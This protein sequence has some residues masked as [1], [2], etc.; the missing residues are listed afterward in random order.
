MVLIKTLATSSACAMALAWFTG[1]PDPQAPPRPDGPPRD[2]EPRRFEFGPGGPGG[3]GGFPGRGPGGFGG[4]GG[5]GGMFGGERKL[6]EKFDTDKNGWLDSGERKAARE[7][8]KSE[9]G[10]GRPGGP[11]GF[12]PPGGGPPGGFGGREEVSPKPGPRV[13]VADVKPVDE[14]T[15][16][17]DPETIRTIF[18]EFEN[19]DWDAEMAEFYKSDVEVPAKMIVDGKEYPNVGVGYRGM[20]SFMAVPAGGKR[21]LNISMD[22]VD[23][24]QKLLGYKTLNLLNAHEDPSFLHTALYLDMARQHIPA[25]KANFV[26]VVINGESWGLYVSAQQFNKE[27]VSENFQSSK[28]ARWKVPGSP[29]GRGGLEY[30]GDDIEAYRR[31]YTI[32]SDDNDKSWKALIKLCKTLNETPAEQ[33]EEALKPMLDIDGTLWFL[34]LE[35]ALI[36]ND[37]YWTRASDYCMYLDGDGKFH[38]IPHDA[39]E[40]LSTAMGGPPG[41]MRGRGPGGFGGPGGPGGPGGFGPPGGG[42]GGPPGF[43]PPPE[44]GPGPGSEAQPPRGERPPQDRD[45]DRPRPDGDRGPRPGDQAGPGGEGRREEDRGNFRF[46]PGG[47]GGPGGPGFGGPG[48]GVGVKLDPLVGL[49]DASKPLRSKLLKVPALKE[50]YLQ[51]VKTIATES[52]DWKNLGPKVDAYAKLIEPEVAADTRKLSTPAAF[53]QAVAAGPANGE[54]PPEGR[55]RISLK[56][57]ADQRRE[58]LLSHEAIKGLGK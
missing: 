24:K 17:Y 18:L 27:F 56:E 39:N 4:P 41:G 29:M 9:P 21:S 28:G 6:V 8:L 42:F 58:F 22:L 48:G 3:P 23:G 45:G 25:P 54:K 47:F 34:A 33:L 5:P 46:G 50:R 40:T 1:Q 16:L 2:G 37:G 14:K 30:L 13:G 10:F 51:M 7:S 32:K 43:G 19:D 35:C 26:R 20:S 57:F 12:G 31:I 44:G 11:R 36:N 53:Q 55:R 52:L 49:E 38:I 15:P